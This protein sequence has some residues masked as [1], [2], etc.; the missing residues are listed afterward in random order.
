[1]NW[2]TGCKLRE[3]QTLG[4]QTLTEI[5]DGTFLMKLNGTKPRMTFARRLAAR[6]MI[7]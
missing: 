4:L 6:W 5:G 3:N 2:M 1:M 7:C